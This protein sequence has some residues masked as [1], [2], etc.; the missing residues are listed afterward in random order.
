M[1]TTEHA[2]E[3]PIEEVVYVKDRPLLDLLR[4]VAIGVYL[5]I[6]AYIVVSFVLGF[7]SGLVNVP[8]P[9]IYLEE[10]DAWAKGVL[11]LAPS[12]G[13]TP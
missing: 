13:A 1:T 3:L 6:A 10:L 8:P 2:T 5:L 11:G 7:V 4:S 9:V 12:Q